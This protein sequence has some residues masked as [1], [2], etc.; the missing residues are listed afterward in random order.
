MKKILIGLLICI[1]LII[2]FAID[3]SGDIIATSTDITIEEITLYHD[4]DLLDDVIEIEVKDYVDR[5]YRIETVTYPAI[6]TKEL[7][8]TS[9]DIGIA[10]VDSNGDVT[11]TGKGFGEVKIFCQSKNN[12]TIRAT[13]T[14]YV[15][16]KELYSIQIVK[17][18]A[19]EYEETLSA[20]VGDTL[21]LTKV[22]LPAPAIKEKKIVWSSSNESVA[23]I[24]G[25]GIVKAISS[26][27]TEITASVYEPGRGEY[28]TSTISL[29]VNASSS[30]LKKNRLVITSD[31]VD[32]SAY[33]YSNSFELVAVEGNADA[34]GTTLTYN[35]AEAGEV[36][37]VVKQGD[38][39]ENLTVKFTKGALELTCE[40]LDTLYETLWSNGAYVNLQNYEFVLNAVVANDDYTGEKPQNITYTIGDT[41]V[42]SRDE[43]GSMLGLLGGTTTIS[44]SASGFATIEIAIEV[45]I[46]LEYV[47]I[48]IDNDEDE[49]GIEGVR[50]W[51]DKFAVKV[52]SL[53]EGYDLSTVTRPTIDFIYGYVNTYKFEIDTYRPLGADLTFEYYSTNED[54]ATVDSD[55]VITFKKEAIGH[56]VGVYMMA[57]YSYGAGSARDGYVFNVVDGINLGWEIKETDDCVNLEKLTADPSLVNYDMAMMFAYFQEGWYW[58]Y[59]RPQNCVDGKQ[60]KK[61]NIILQSDIYYHKDHWEPYILTSIYG[62]GFKIDSRFKKHEGNENFL[63]KMNRSLGG[64]IV[65]QNVTLNSA[66]PPTDSG[67]WSAL[68]ENGGYIAGIGNQFWEDWDYV[69]SG[70]CGCGQGCVGWWV[71]PTWVDKTWDKEYKYDEDGYTLTRETSVTFRYCQV[72]NTFNSIV[73]KRGNVLVEGCIFRNTVSAAI[74]YNP[75]YADK[76]VF[77]DKTTLT[78]RNCIF[79]NSLA[80]AIMV[81]PPIASAC[82]SEL[83]GLSIEGKNY[84]YNWKKIKDIDLALL[85]E[86][87]LPVPGIAD[88]IN[89]QVNDIFKQVLAREEYDD[90]KVKNRETGSARNDDYVNLTFC[91]LGLWYDP[92]QIPLSYDDGEWKSV[93]ADVKNSGGN[94]LVTALGKHPIQLLMNYSDSES[95]NTMPGENYDTASDSEGNPIW[96]KRLR[97]IA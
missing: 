38:T 41:G 39:E 80:P 59:D 22:V 20:R 70:H 51:G 40:N 93:F 7:V 97:G 11:F 28:L 65:F 2:V 79:A 61:E 35:G 62:N 87:S 82:D 64:D 18:G 30:L 44:A 29:T 88:M 83:M 92:T 57:K 3:I 47:A 86:E 27:V 76:S 73:V 85:E 45:K 4:G 67:D 24:D 26:G 15:S 63:L 37:L 49:R 12:L 43:D 90:M 36:S 55:G 95:F 91:A 10:Q 94:S 23:T 16:G 21:M 71:C 78:V 72:Q 68:K 34:S 17:Q 5:A 84:I 48:T 77:K 52:D 74:M 1:P 25:N 31:T 9:S 56:Q 75:Q 60:L 13:A 42:L 96:I 32:L 53:P 6:A 19:T 33:A 50:V 89:G 54:Y 46:P 66:T 14:F 81:T 8:W 69:Y 58:E